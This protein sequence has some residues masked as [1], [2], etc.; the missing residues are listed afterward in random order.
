MLP[1][2]VV[3]ALSVE[4]MLGWV[5]SGKKASFKQ[6]VALSQTSPVD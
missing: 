1:R 5:I 3:L 6:C 2:E 4:H